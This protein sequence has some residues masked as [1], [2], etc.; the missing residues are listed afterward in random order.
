MVRHRINSVAHGAKCAIKIVCHRNNSVAHHVH[1]RHRINTFCGAPQDM[2][3][4]KSVGPTSNH[5]TWSIWL[6][7]V[8]HRGWCAT[9]I[10]Y[11]VAHDTGCATEIEHSVA[12]PQ[13]CATESCISVAHLTRCATESLQDSRKR[14]HTHFP[15]MWPSSFSPLHLA[16][17]P[18]LSYAILTILHSII[19]CEISF[20]CH[21]IGEDLGRASIYILL[22]SFCPLFSLYHHTH[23]SHR[24]RSRRLGNRSRSTTW[25]LL[26]EYVYVCTWSLCV[27]C[28]VVALC[29]AWI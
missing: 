25:V 9:E 12:H 4:R 27:L 1:M 6:N 3:H 19:C 20:V 16:R 2:R 14:W 5:W 10:W 22:L 23:L 18:P 17:A 24:S 8:A 11:S 21:I 28:H 29:G 13:A 26:D 15:H 7:S